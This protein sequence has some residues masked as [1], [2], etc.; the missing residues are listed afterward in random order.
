MEKSGV[1]PPAQLVP[2]QMLS[3][4]CNSMPFGATPV[5]PC[6]TSKKPT[7]VTVTVSFAVWKEVLTAY[8]ASNA[9]RELVTCVVHELPVRQPGYGISAIN[10]RPAES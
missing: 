3:T 4:E 2:Q 1:A 9:L 10:V 8:L 5:C 7:P 6:S